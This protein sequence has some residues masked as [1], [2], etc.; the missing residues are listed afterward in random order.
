LQVI[1][2]NTGPGARVN[3]LTRE[4]FAK[5]LAALDPDRT[6]AAEKYEVLRRKLVKLFEYQKLIH[7]EELA[8]ETIDR[9]VK[10]LETEEIHNISLFAYGVAR[11]ICLEARRKKSK[12]ISIQDH[13]NSSEELCAGDPD[14]EESII[15]ELGN[16]QTLECLTKC[17]RSLPLGYHELIIEYYQGEK[18]VRI[19]RRKDLARKRGI[20]IEALRC[21]ANK[22]RDKLRCCVNRCLNVRRLGRF[23]PGASLREKGELG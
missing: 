6:R 23:T 20:T 3:K 12:Y 19:K 11:N 14:P 22:V 8:D 18:Q 9:L 5:F 17:L 4:E 21:E 10:R 15:T 16:A 1:G 13:Y 7:I 2:K